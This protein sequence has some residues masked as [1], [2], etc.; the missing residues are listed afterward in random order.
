MQDLGDDT[1]MESEMRVLRGM[2]FS[3]AWARLGLLSSGG[4]LQGAI[5]WCIENPEVYYRHML[6]SVGVCSEVVFERV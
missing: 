2:G 3:M 6:A 4:Q 1:G 5:D